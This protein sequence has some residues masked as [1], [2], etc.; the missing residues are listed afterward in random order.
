MRPRSVP[1]I[2]TGVLAVVLA[3]PSFAVDNVA[4]QE[5]LGAR[6]GY[7]ETY[8]G[9]NEYYGPGWDVTLY[10]NEHIWSRLFLDVHVGA[11]YLGDLLDPELDDDITNTP[12]IESEM[13]TFYFSVGGI[14][15]I[16]LGSYTLTTSLAAGIYS[17][18]V[19]LAADFVADDLS[20]QYF[21]GQAGLGLVRRVGTNWSLEANGTVHYFGTN[22]AIDD[23]L[24]VF[25]NTKAEDPVMLGISV[26]FAIDLR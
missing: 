25:T 9:V 10:F 22:A 15:G 8:D 16:P 11:I 2:V 13:R 17:V 19:A 21:G 7:I 26:G 20:D 12:G 4:G 1:L 5:R 3:R 24:W 23:L 14:Y 18:S 6:V